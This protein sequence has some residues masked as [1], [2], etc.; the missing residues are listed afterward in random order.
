M[1]TQR[2]T[3]DGFVSAVKQC[4]GIGLGDLD[5]LTTVLVKTINTLYRIIVLEPPRSTISGSA[6]RRET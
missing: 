4:D 1:A 3:L 2:C 5:A 6:S